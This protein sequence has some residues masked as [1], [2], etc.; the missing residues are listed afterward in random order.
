[1]STSI[2]PTASMQAKANRLLE[3]A[4]RWARGVR[5]V[6]GLPFVSFAGSAPGA[7][8]FTSVRGCTCPSHRHR[9]VCSHLLAVQADAARIAREHAEIDAL[10]GPAPKRPYEALF[11]ACKSGCGDLADTLDQYCSKCASDREWEA[12]REAWEARR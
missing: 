9:G 8:Y 7:V 12:R 6:D 10:L 4:D 2:V 5:H 3:S 11:P 1:M